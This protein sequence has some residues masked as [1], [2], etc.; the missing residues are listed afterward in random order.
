MRYSRFR[1]YLARQNRDMRAR[2]MRNPYG[3]R[4]G[5]VVSDRRGDY[6]Y[7]GNS[8]MDYA[9]QS[10]GSNGDRHYPM[11]DYARGSNSSQSSGQSRGSD[12]NYEDMNYYPI[13]RMGTFDYNT[14]GSDYGYEDYDMR[15]GRDYN[16]DM[17]GR[18]DY[19]EDDYKLTPSEIRKWEKELKQ[20]GGANFTPDQVRQVAQQHGIRF[21]EFSPELL[22]VIANAMYS[23]YGETVKGDISMYVKMAKDFLCDEDFDGEPEEKAY[24]Y[25]NAIVNKED[26]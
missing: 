15:G 11:F 19:G 2:D 14:Y 17:R 1:E 13:R 9:R 20:N 22:T 5:Y 7:A 10:R 4:G 25:Y 24:L 18:R 12:R 21:D 6:D 26:D 16:Y 8:N 23:D 3:S